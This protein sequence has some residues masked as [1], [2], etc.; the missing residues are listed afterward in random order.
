VVM[1]TVSLVALAAVH[2]E[3]WHLVVGKALIALANGLCVTAMMTGT[4]TAV[5]AEDTG[6]AT[7]LILVSRVLGYAVGGQLGGAL[8]TAATP[9]GSDVA[10]ESAYVTGFVLAAV[11]TSLALFVARTL[12]EGVEE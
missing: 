12:P 8:L 11:V 7:S 6:V 9:P 10:A 2:T 5:D 4:A 3:V 1:M